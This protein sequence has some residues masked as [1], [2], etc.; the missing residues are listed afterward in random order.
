[1]YVFLTALIIRLCVICSSSRCALP[2]HICR[3]FVRQ[4]HGW[5]YY[6]CL[7]VKSKLF[8]RMIPNIYPGENSGS[9]RQLQPQDV[10][11]NAINRQSTILNSQTQYYYKFYKFCFHSS[12]AS[13][14]L[15]KACSLP[16]NL[17]KVLLLVVSEVIIQ[18]EVIFW[19]TCLAAN[20]LSVRDISFIRLHIIYR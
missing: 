3:C 10:V 2:I 14:I 18:F 12:C 1:M 13:S 9:D 15:I 4:C 8:R 7:N 11:R 16:H 6:V 5:D 20:T 17:F 19:R